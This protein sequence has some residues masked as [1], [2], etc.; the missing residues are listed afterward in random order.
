MP[1]RLRAR[2]VWVEPAAIVL[3]LAVAGVVGAFI[4]EW[5]WTAPVG[6]VVDH[7]WV[8]EDEA[9]LQ[10][11]FDATGWY[12]VIA[13]AL[14]LLVGLGVALFLDRVPLLTLVAVIVGSALGTFLMLRIGAAL[15]PPDPHTVALDS[16]DGTHLPGQLE[17]SGW[18][19][20]IALPAGALV[21][22][23]VVFIGL[24]P[25]R[26]FPADDVHTG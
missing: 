10:G 19:P 6:V 9:G 7:Q 8:A 23:A 16:P 20:W 24:S 18:S 14:G 25:R 2:P 15:G 4:W 3:L 17:V 12:V 11:M 22:L 5:L 21:G 26:Q 1:D 13:S